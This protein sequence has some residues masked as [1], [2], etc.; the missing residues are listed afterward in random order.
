MPRPRKDESLVTVVLNQSVAGHRTDEKGNVRSTFS[1]AAKSKM[2]L[3]ADE[4]KRYV[5][6]GIASYPSE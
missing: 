6:A 5:D 1:Y 4:A 2:D 3:P